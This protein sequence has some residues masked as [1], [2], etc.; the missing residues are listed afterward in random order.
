[1]CLVIAVLGAITVEPLT[2]NLPRYHSH[3]LSGFC[4]FPLLQEAPFLVVEGS[5]GG[6]RVW[7][8]EPGWSAVVQSQL[9]TTSASW[10]QAILLHQPPK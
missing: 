10:V 7:L 4:S 5:F 3:R 2:P 1:M 8:Y 6:N 9:T